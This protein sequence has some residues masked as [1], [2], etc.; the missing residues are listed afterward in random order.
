MHSQTIFPEDCR[1][2][3]SAMVYCEYGCRSGSC[4]TTYRI[5]DSAVLA[6]VIYVTEVELPQWQL[7]GGTSS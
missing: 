7:L 2:E 5:E 4:R 1:I 3:C 6:V